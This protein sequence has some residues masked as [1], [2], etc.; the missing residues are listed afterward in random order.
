MVFPRARPAGRAGPVAPL[1]LPPNF[2]LLPHAMADIMLML[3]EPGMPGSPDMHDQQ[4]LALLGRS[5]VESTII[6]GL[7]HP[8][9]RVTVPRCAGSHADPSL[10][11]H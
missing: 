3:P 1:H 10:I 8:H 7:L 4:P 5:S 11:R 9:G 2:T 6:R